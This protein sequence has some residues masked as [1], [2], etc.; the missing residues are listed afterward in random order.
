MKGNAADVA[1]F[2]TPSSASGSLALMAAIDIWSFGMK[3][4]R[5]FLRIL[6]LKSQGKIVSVVPLMMDVEDLAILI[7]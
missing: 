5:I 6:Q 3:N 1:V 2:L 4:M 7:I